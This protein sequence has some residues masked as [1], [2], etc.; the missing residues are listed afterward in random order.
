M[1]DFTHPHFK[2]AQEEIQ[3]LMRSIPKE[4][5]DIDQLFTRVV[6]KYLAVLAEHTDTYDQVYGV[7]YDDDDDED[8]S[9]HPDLE[10]SLWIQSGAH[11]DWLNNNT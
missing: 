9:Y 1:I 7:D 5:L 2:G 11:R 8:Q 4:N 3:Q 6:G 10:L